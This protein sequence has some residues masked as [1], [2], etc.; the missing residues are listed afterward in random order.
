MKYRFSDLKLFV[1]PNADGMSKFS[2]LL[3]VEFDFPSIVRVALAISC[4]LVRGSRSG[5]EDYYEV[6]IRLYEGTNPQETNENH[7]GKLYIAVFGYPY[8]TTF[9]T[10]VEKFEWYEDGSF[11]V[12]AANGE[13]HHVTPS[14]F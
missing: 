3:N 5:G 12:I 13:R 11:D 4:G 14:K 8:N 9:K 6:V 1:T 2:G 7:V 10:R